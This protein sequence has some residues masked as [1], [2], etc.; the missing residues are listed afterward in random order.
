MVM[1]DASLATDSMAIEG[2]R[3]AAPLTF[4]VFDLM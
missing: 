4:V 1:P 2:G 3:P